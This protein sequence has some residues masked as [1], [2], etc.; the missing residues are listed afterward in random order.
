MT[1][2][3]LKDEKT[4]CLCLLIPYKCEEMQLIKQ[5]TMGVGNK[6]FLLTQRKLHV[7][8]HICTYA[9]KHCGTYFG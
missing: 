2:E 3:Q 9:I 1:I 7:E 4:L 8:M 5:F 6:G